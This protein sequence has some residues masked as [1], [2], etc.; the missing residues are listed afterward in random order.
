[1]IVFT[2]Y[3]IVM[4]C[5]QLASAKYIG[6]CIKF[7]IIIIIIISCL[8]VFRPVT[9]VTIENVPCGIFRSLASPRAWNSHT[10]PVSRH[11]YRLVCFK[12]TNGTFARLARA[13]FHFRTHPGHSHLINEEKIFHL[14]CSCVDDMHTRRQISSIL[15]LSPERPFQFYSQIVCT[16]NDL[17]QSRKNCVTF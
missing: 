12:Y 4:L 11:F 1:M 5:P 10:K 2:I 8:G 14:L 7:I 3:F 17:E 16:S 6:T 15:F 9:F 13:F